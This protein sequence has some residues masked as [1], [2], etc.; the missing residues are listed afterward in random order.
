MSKLGKRSECENLLLTHRNCSEGKRNLLCIWTM[1][2]EDRPALVKPTNPSSQ[3][4]GWLR[5][6]PALGRRLW[7]LTRFLWLLPPLR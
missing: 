4:A 2:A 3:L 5:A 7:R 1:E 6:F